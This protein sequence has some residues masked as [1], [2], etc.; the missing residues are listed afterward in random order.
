MLP[1]TTPWMAAWSTLLPRKAAMTPVTAAR[2]TT[3]MTHQ[4]GRR[5]KRRRPATIEGQRTMSEPWRR[6]RLYITILR[7][8]KLSRLRASNPHL[9]AKLLAMLARLG[10][11]ARCMRASRTFPSAEH[12]EGGD[13]HDRYEPHGEREEKG[14]DRWPRGDENQQSHHAEPIR[15]RA[16]GMGDAVV[17]PA[18]RLVGRDRM[19]PEEDCSLARQRSV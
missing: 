16:G 4:G 15:V 11:S 10:T 7:T 2:T 6:G 13:R 5:M 12:P 14:V 8:Q 9:S 17:L 3:A 1:T 19:V 18:S